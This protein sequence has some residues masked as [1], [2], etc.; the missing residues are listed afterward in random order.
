MENT[1]PII[2]GVD[3]SEASFEA[4]REAK[5]M[6]EAL[7]CPLT[8][9]MMGWVSC[10]TLPLCTPCTTALLTCDHRRRPGPPGTTFARRSRAGAY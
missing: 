1:Q 4:L 6:A 7:G 5:T 8:A 3:G 9:T 10:I 2:V